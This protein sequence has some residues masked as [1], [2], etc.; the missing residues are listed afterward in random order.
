M[1][2]KK[3]FLKMKVGYNSSHAFDTLFF[4]KSGK[5][6]FVRKTWK[7]PYNTLNSSEEVYTYSDFEQAVHYFLIH[8][9][10]RKNNG[11]LTQEDIDAAVQKLRI[12]NNKLTSEGAV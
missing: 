11:V 3:T 12:E 1:K 4:G 5:A 6:Y 8:L 9:T 10:V 7:N 2:N